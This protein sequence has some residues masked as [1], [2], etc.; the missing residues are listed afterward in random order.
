[1]SSQDFQIAPT[2]WILDALRLAV[3]LC[4][5]SCTSEYAREFSPD[6]SA[7][8]QNQ[9]HSKG[10]LFSSSHEPACSVSVVKL[11]FSRSYLPNFNQKLRQLRVMCNPSVNIK[12]SFWHLVSIKLF[13]KSVGNV[14]LTSRYRFLK[15]FNSGTVA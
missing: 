15:P 14:H 2:S 8:K 10:Y 6:C 3:A 13:H 1:M 12:I 9:N 7:P 5:I 4:I 11:G